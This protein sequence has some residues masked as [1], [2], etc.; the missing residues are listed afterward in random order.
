MAIKT[1]ANRLEG[2]RRHEVLLL[3][4][5]E[6]GATG[7]ELG[8]ASGGFSRRMLESGRFKHFFGVDMYADG[9]DID[10]Y[11]TAL[12]TVGLYSPYTLLRMTF[13]E[14]YDLFEDESLDF[15][16]IDGYAHSGQEGGDT[17]WKWS[18]K[19]RVGGVIAGDDYDPHWPLVQQAVHR[20]I[21]DTGFQLH[22]TTET[23]PDVAYA[24]FPS[25]A[26]IKSAPFFGEAPAEM[27][28][29]GKEAARQVAR[30][31]GRLR[32]LEQ[33][34]KRHMPEDITER[35]RTWN[36]ERKSRRSK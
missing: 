5:K 20:F 11:K 17:I 8:V 36:R 3:L 24:D 12:R 30:K 15:I 21:A 19:V 25:W 26:T 23:E 9:H 35:L 28:A 6:E 27:V 7:V 32:P 14:A 29:A 34:L 18:R 1:T 4:N 10:Q 16:Y 33:F 31:R 2:R 13:D 22:H